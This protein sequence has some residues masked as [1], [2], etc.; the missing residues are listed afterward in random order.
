M[1]IGRILFLTFGCILLALGVG[2]SMADDEDPVDMQRAHIFT[3]GGIGLMVGGAACGAAER[4]TAH[5]PQPPYPLVQPQPHLPQPHLPQGHAFPPP[6]A[7]E[8]GH[9]LPQYEPGHTLPQGHG[10]PY[11]PA[12]G[13][14]R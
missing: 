8:P 6:Q 1:G 9:T 11:P 14:A 7:Y 12:G 13:S 5:P 4:R 3:L 2:G 10:T